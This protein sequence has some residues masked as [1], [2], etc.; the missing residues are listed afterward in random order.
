[1]NYQIDICEINPDEPDASAGGIRKKY[2]RIGH[3]IMKKIRVLLLLLVVLMITCIALVACNTND[4]AAQD[5]SEGHTW[6]NASNPKR[7]KLIQSR[8]CTLPEI[9][10]R[11]CRVCGEKEQY[12]SADPAGHRYDST[13]K[14]YLNDATCTENGHTIN[15][16]YWYERC[17]YTA[18]IIEEVPGT[19]TG[20]TFL[21]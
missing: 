3:S 4:D 11:E 7:Q 5:C 16:C 18:A 20:H 15:Q 14:I 13:K 19:A 10:E 21:M 12:V 6:R 9:R 8:T 2:E 17:G 1:M